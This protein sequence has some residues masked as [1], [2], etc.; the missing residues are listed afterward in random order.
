MVLLIIV[1]A[2][3]S[4]LS[5]WVFIRPQLS[6]FNG[7]GAEFAFL[8][9]PEFFHVAP[10]GG[11]N[12]TAFV[13]RSVGFS[14]PIRVE[15]LNPP[16]WVTYTSLTLN[17][18]D[19]NATFA[20]G[21]SQNA[22]LTE[23][24]LTIRAS[25]AGTADQYSVIDV[26]VVGVSN[27][28]SEFGSGVAYDTTKVLDGDT[29]KSLRSYQ[30]GTFTF[31]TLT[32]QLQSLE[33]GDVIL[34]PPSA[35]NTAQSG[36][37]RLVLSTSE[38]GGEFVVQTNQATLFDEFQ[39]LDVGGGSLNVTASELA[40]SGGLGPAQATGNILSRSRPDV[41][42][43]NIWITLFD[44]SIGV[45]GRNIGGDVMFS[46]EG[47]L[48]AKLGPAIHIHMCDYVVPCLTMFKLHLIFLEDV[49]VSLTG[50]AGSQLNWEESV[51]TLA[52]GNIPILGPLLWVDYSLT[53]DG[54]AS[55]PLNQNIDGSWHQ[56]YSV[57]LGP[58]WDNDN[59]WT[60][61]QVS[62]GPSIDKHFQITMGS[63]SEAKLGIGPRAEAGING[64]VIIASAGVK[65]S[66]AAYFMIVLESQIPKPSNKPSSWW[67]DWEIDGKFV[68]DFYVSITL[69]HTWSKDFCIP[70]DC[71]PGTIAGPYSLF[72]GWPLPPLVRITS[73]HD[74][75]TLD[76]NTLLFLP[77]FTATATGEDGDQCKTSPP[78]NLIWS[79]EYG[80]IGMGCTVTGVKLTHDGS[81]T[82]TFTVTDST[83]ASSSDSITVNVNSPRPDVYITKPQNNQNFLVGEP[84][85][86][87]GYAVIHTTNYPCNQP[88][89]QL[90]FSIWL[91]SIVTSQPEPGGQ[92][93]TATWTF[94]Q[95]GTYYLRLVAKNNQNQ[96]IGYSKLVK[97]N[98][99]A[100]SQGTNLPPQVEITSPNNLQSFLYLN[101]QIP[102]VGK[103]Y[104]AE[105]DQMGTY[106]WSY[107][108]MS[109]SQSSVTITT[110]T[111]P[112]T[113]TQQ[114]P[115]YVNASLNTNTFC[116]NSP[117]GGEIAIL[118]E[119]TETSPVAQAGKSQPVIIH[120]FCEQ[121][122]S[123]GPIIT[124]PPTATIPNT[125]PSSNRP[126]LPS[127]EI[128]D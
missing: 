66:L 15:V 32:P 26:K 101:Y 11:H 31:T 42:I 21:A 119:A 93:C 63:G 94:N 27:V 46:G 80:K 74:G 84:V 10:G 113:C 30:N 39:T 73:P 49:D 88:S 53:L 82:I 79:D 83:G 121:V 90:V 2:V 12:V 20:I 8:L 5:Y 75:D 92:F 35:T 95:P 16:S 59:G 23:L 72:D 47:K 65:G 85:T 64:S 112:S 102:L 14:G 86:L 116:T 105:N 69:V 77:S 25:S 78:Q 118:L 7:S 17:S 29:L 100:P 3:A 117:T 58:T 38:E 70:G 45:T 110:G 44:A 9:N 126:K 34:V 36:L 6:T 37:M 71:N 124:S 18:T 4:A 123:I 56:T 98:V 108:P 115:C 107:A 68:I 19:T 89:G 125:L 122:A 103:I 50:S 60:W 109:M 55:G 87:E 91:V 51:D 67:V 33:R 99:L 41:T 13:E 127:C 52:S 43:D 96:D 128:V 24:N 61:Y 114:S 54:T 57:E 40:A 120:L 81:D 97:I 28:T 106:T 104:D 1:L 48:V 22:P 111:L 62:N 76:Y